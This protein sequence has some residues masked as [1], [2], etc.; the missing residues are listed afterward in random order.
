LAGLSH[1]TEGVSDGDIANGLPFHMPHL[2]PDR[3]FTIIEKIA[4]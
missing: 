2:D 1:G 3:R 4:A